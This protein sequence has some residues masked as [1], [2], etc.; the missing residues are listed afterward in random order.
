VTIDATPVVVDLNIDLTAHEA[1]DG[2]TTDTRFVARKPSEKSSRRRARSGP[3]G[4]RW[5]VEG[6]AQLA[7]FAVAALVLIPLAWTI[8]GSLK[9]RNDLY[10][11]PLKVLPS[12][13]E[14]TNYSRA[15][16]QVPFPTVYLNSIVTTLASTVIKVILGSTTAF[17]LVF[18]NFPGR[19][20]AFWF[21][22]ASLMVPFEVVLIPNF[23]TVSELGW[24]DTWF[25][26]VI[27]NAGVAFG[28]FLLHQSF[29][30]IPKEVIEAADLDGVSRVRLLTRVV[31]PMSRPAITAFA[32][33]TAVTKWNEYLWP[34][35]VT[36]KIGSATLPLGL[37][38]LRDSEGA[39]EWGPILAGTVLVVVPILP[40]LVFAQKRLVS[41]LS[42]GVKG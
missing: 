2:R 6:F 37:T 42:G 28:A 33:I 4:S 35:I 32:L 34:R 30:S 12:H 17:A 41:G 29:L 19:R 5:G 38:L 36:S 14:T 40:F 15:W 9:D 1:S 21:V 24:L 7:V 13:L 11:R 31:A 10:S 25:G 26:I 23:V 27:P 16:D 39:N 8:L 22:V 3:A 20:M 18:L